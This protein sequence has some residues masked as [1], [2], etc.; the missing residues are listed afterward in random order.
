[1]YDYIKGIVT[2]VKYNSIV[3]DNNGVGYL[4]CAFRAAGINIEVFPACS[5]VVSVDKVSII[6]PYK[7]EVFISSFEELEELLNIQEMKAI[8]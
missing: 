3:V 8:M 4:I 7:G 1:M 6:V 2:Y 5:V